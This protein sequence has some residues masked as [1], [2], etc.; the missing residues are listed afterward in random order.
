MIYN[1]KA[2]RTEASWQ[3]VGNGAAEAAGDEKRVSGGQKRAFRMLFL[4]PCQFLF[5]L[6]LCCSYSFLAFFSFLL[7]GK[8]PGKVDGKAARMKKRMKK[9]LCQ[10]ADIVAG[11][12]NEQGDICGRKPKNVRIWK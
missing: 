1:I 11:K 12:T 4:F 7:P 10:G 9:N 2:S 8:M 3:Q 6:F 5:A